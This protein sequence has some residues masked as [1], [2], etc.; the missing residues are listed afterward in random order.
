MSKKIVLYI[1]VVIVSVVWGF[2]FVGSKTALETLSPMQVL[3]ARWTLGA[4]TLVLLALLRIIKVDYRNKPKAPLAALMIFQP[5]VYS[6]C[7]M[8]GID[9]TTA[10][11]SAII[12][13]MI[14]LAVLIISS[15]AYRTKVKPLAILGIFLAFGGVLC[16][17]VFSPN[18]SL[19][20]KAAGYLLLL[21][22]VTA[23]AIYSIR[24]NRVARIYSPMEITIVMTSTGAVFFNIIMI[25]QGQG[26]S[27]YPTIF[28]SSRLML[29]IAFLGFGCTA[30]CY[31]CYN[32][33]I[34]YLPPH[35]ASTIQVNLIT[36][37][38]V[39]SGIFVGGDPYGIYT[40]VGM[41]LMVGGLVLTGLNAGEKSEKSADLPA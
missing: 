14:P 26:V 31:L 35:V 17:T 11:E 23:G 21:G 18:F 7:E 3:S 33:I 40:A 30:L 24:T 13:S 5:C 27:V 36:L 12:I 34:S 2:S 41:V 25:A 37:V 22:A 1:S 19:G 8:V 9:K 4:L 39:I 38:G 6:I 32:V 29:A 28:E 16:T 10:S 15:L 20:G